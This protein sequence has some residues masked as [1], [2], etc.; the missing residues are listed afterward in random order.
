MGGWQGDEGGGGR[1]ETGSFFSGGGG[2]LKCEWEHHYG[3]A[4]T[5]LFHV[6]QCTAENRQMIIFFI[7]VYITIFSS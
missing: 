6:E 3:N 1:A 4:H 5:A 7:Y 2:G